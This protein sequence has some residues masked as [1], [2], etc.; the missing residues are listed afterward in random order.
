MYFEKAQK[1]KQ[2]NLKRA[3]NVRLN[4]TS[5]T[6]LVVSERVPYGVCNKNKS[7]QVSLGYKDIS[8]SNF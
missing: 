8:K 1:T 7:Q 2:T 4:E 3:L 5:L 6:D